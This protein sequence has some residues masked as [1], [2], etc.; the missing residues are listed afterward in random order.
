MRT[1][2]TT[3]YL[4]KCAF[5]EA[6]ANNNRVFDGEDWVYSCGCFERTFIETGEHP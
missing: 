4:F 2:Q 6:P 3:L 1:I 5:C